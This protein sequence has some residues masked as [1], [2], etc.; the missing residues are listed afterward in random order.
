VSNGC[1]IKEIKII[2]LFNVRKK[3]LC[4]V[5]IHQEWANFFSGE[6]SCRNPE[7]PV[8]L[9]LFGMLIQIQQRIEVYLEEF[10]RNKHN[11]T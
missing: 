2:S 3:Q 8:P 10:D 4:L 5:T 11:N 6:V 7:I 9:K 1:S